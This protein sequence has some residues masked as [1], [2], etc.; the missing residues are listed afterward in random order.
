MCVLC[1]GAFVQTWRMEIQLL[2]VPCFSKHFIFDEFEMIP[3]LVIMSLPQTPR[4]NVII[5]LGQCVHP[6]AP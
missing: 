2:I 4:H 6:P 5:I 1:V 3:F